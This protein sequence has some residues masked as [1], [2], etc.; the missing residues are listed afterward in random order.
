MSQPYEVIV[1]CGT[2]GAKKVLLLR[3]MLEMAVS[4]S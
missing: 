2:Q 1:E 3:R 4:T